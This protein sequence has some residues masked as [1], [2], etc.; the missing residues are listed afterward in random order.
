ML[1][2]IFAIGWIGFLQ[3]LRSRIY[4]NLLVAGIGLIVCALAFDQLAGG[5]GRRVLTD[6]GLAFISLLIAVLAGTTAI[7]AVTR[8]IE[9][10]H[11][12][13]LLARPLG[14]SELILG[15]FTTT[16]MLVV[17]ANGLLGLLLG[18]LVGVAGGSPFPVLCA[19]LFC[20]LEGLIVGALAILFGVGSSSTMSAVFTTTIFLLGRLT[21]PMKELLDAGKLRGPIEP[22]MQGAYRVL[23]QFFR[24]DLTEYARGGQALDPIPLAYGATY[25]LCYVGMLLSFAIWRFRRRDLL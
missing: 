10:K 7:M 16:A 11:I 18:L 15:R 23:P 20:S 19:V 21:L 25:G 14:R 8:E 5:E 17:T 24:F 22:L 4:I 9:S 13:L 2:R 1:G 6:L 3:L 12:H